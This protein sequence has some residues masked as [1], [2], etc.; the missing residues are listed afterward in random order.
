MEQQARVGFYAI[1]ASCVL[2]AVQLVQERLEAGSHILHF[3]HYK[4]FFEIIQISMVWTL[5][6]LFTLPV[7]PLDTIRQHGR[8][9]HVVGYITNDKAVVTIHLCVLDRAIYCFHLNT[10]MIALVSGSNFSL[11]NAVFVLPISSLTYAAPSKE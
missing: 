5:E 8:L 3:Q 1:T 10:S 2:V 4:L 6:A 7:I 9:N 11:G